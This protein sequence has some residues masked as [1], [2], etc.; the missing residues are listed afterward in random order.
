MELREYKE[1]FEALYKELKADLGTD[2]NM[3]IIIEG[4]S[5]VFGL[6]TTEYISVKLETRM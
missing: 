1:K 6:G 2:K 4:N 3:T 5:N